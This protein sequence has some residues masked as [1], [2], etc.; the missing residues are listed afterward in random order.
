M[1]NIPG[2]SQKIENEYDEIMVE[3]EKSVK[4]YKNKFPAFT[5]I[6][7]LGREHADILRDME[8]MRAQ[9]ESALEGWVYL[10][11]GLSRRSGAH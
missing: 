9:E 8:S 4:P 2:V 3:L 5:Q 6:P 1:K 11:C 7:A 10:R